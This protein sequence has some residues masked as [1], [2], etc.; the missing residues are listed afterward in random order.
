MKLVKRFLKQKQ[1]TEKP[2][3][4]PEAEPEARA[5]SATTTGTCNQMIYIRVQVQSVILTNLD[6][7]APPHLYLIEGSLDDIRRFAGITVD[8]IIKVA[9]SICDP[10]G[11]AGRFYT[12]TTETPSYWYNRNR[13]QIHWRQVALGD[14]LVPGIYEFMSTTS[15]TLSKISER[16]NRSLT[17]AGSKSDATTFRRHLNER[18]GG[19]VVTLTHSISPHSETYRFRW[20]KGHCYEICG[21][22]DSWSSQVSPEHWSPPLRCFGWFGRSLWARFLSRHGEKPITLWILII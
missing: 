16:P 3:A 6:P 21:R 9:N 11:K 17:T 12:H 8:W 2:E 20:C 7:N 10:S 14:A 22:C 19:C 15:I 1:K 4:E 5:Q 13:D 18:D